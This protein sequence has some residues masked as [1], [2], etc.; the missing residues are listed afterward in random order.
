MHVSR[1]SRSV[2]IRWSR[3]REE[4]RQS[5]DDALYQGARVFAG[6]HSGRRGR[7]ANSNPAKRSAG[8]TGS[9]GGEATSLRGND[10]H[11]GS[12]GDDPREIEGREIDGW[13]SFS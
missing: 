7:A 10:A 12:P 4:P 3:D 6:L 13:A 1:A 9:R 2:Q 11:E 5:A 8:K